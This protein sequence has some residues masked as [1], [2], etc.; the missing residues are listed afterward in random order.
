MKIA[1]EL[2]MASVSSFHVTP[3]LPGLSKVDEK[4]SFLAE[5]ESL[6]GN[7]NIMGVKRIIMMSIGT[8]SIDR[9]AIRD[10]R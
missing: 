8:D 5:V 10:G 7:L 2:R 9:V 4:I 3:V 1:C 6:H